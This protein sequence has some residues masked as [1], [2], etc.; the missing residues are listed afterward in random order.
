M[1]QLEHDST[2]YTLRPVPRAWVIVGLAVAGWVVV[3]LMGVGIWA[4]LA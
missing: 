1:S 2:L 3:G 4:L